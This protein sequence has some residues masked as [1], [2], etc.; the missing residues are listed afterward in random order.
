VARRTHGEGTFRFV[1]AAGKQVARAGDAVE[2]HW[3]GTVGWTED[4][5][6]IRKHLRSKTSFADLKG[7]I[8][9]FREQN[10]NGAIRDNERFTVEQWIR[11][12]IEHEPKGR[13]RAK[14]TVVAPSTRAGYFTDL[15][16]IL[17]ATY[18]IG[19]IRLDK[20][21]S[22]NIAAV[23][24]GMLAAGK[25]RGTVVHVQ[26][27]LSAA[28][29]AA[30]RRGRISWNP[31]SE[32]AIP[33]VADAA[34]ARIEP[35]D[36]EESMAILAVAASRR[37]AARWRIALS[38]GVRQ[39]EAL[40]LQREDI[41]F[42]R[43][44]IHIGRQIQ[45]AL[46]EH[47]CADTTRCLTQP[48]RNDARQCPARVPNTHPGAAASRKWVHGCPDRTRCVRT[49]RR[50]AAECQ[51]RIGEGGISVRATKAG[52]ERDVP[53][54]AAMISELRTQ[55]E[56]LDRERANAGEHWNDGPRGGWL[57]PDEFGYPIHKRRDYEEWRSIL[58]AAAVRRARLHD[59]RHTAATNLLDRGLDRA[60][61]QDALGMSDETFKRY[62]HVRD[63][64]RVKIAA[65][66]DDALPAAPRRRRDA[67][68]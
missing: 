14:T 23:Y 49:R 28:M 66:M 62:A 61:I 59:A 44:I 57:F 67:H 9:A 7:K 12:W 45:P 43:R 38:A 1:N 31:V 40:G 15:R 10:S 65:A 6:Q 51:Q 32:V 58:D 4:G 11:H 53:L 50:T 46:F 56:Q 2:W 8:K 29:N 22:A 54:S 19:A 48:E 33:K 47:G 35:L 64:H 17:D 18:G 27:T 41:D 63:E 37:N 42:R 24:D 55:L 52:R 20:L 60:A 25:S 13:G 5:R 30:V 34:T 39:G 3:W 68:S 21:V 16:H 26:R 36:Y